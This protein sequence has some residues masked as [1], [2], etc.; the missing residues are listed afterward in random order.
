MI[1]E[2]D[3]PA[4]IN[5]QQELLRRLG[6]ALGDGTKELT[7][8]FLDSLFTIVKDHR[9]AFRAK[10]VDFPVMVALVV[11]RLG[12]VEFK[13]ADLDLASVKQQIVNF[14]RQYQPRGIRMDEVVWAFKSAYPDLRSDDVLSEQQKGEQA[15]KRMH[16]RMDKVIEEMKTEEANLDD[17]RDGRGAVE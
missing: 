4:M 5:A 1:T 7:K 3:H 13:R 6:I 11:P 9:S 2:E 16:E 10:G 12:I 17:G 14:V 15:T 8:P